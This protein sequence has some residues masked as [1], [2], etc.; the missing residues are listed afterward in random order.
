MIRERASDPRPT[1]SAAT[2]CSSPPP[3]GPRSPATP[4]APASG[5]PPSRPAESPSL[6]HPRP[7]PRPRLLAPRRWIR[8]QG[9]HGSHGPRSRSRPPR[10]TC[11]RCPKPTEE[12]HRPQPHPQPRTD[13][14]GA[15]R[16]VGPR[17][18]QLASPPVQA[19]QHPRTDTSITCATPPS[20]SATSHELDVARPLLETGELRP[21]SS[22]DREEPDS[23]GGSVSPRV[24]GRLPD[25]LSGDDR[26]D[27]TT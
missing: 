9:R 2:T 6:P 12:P 21:N 16:R 15:R 18:D 17:A 10:N 23:Q 24:P 1:T 13:R 5:Y 25:G 7:A 3:A 19:H 22:L 4:S 20:R 11:T 26:P 27:V 14:R 8:P